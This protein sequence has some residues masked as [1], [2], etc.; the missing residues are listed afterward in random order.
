[1]FGR[2]CIAELKRLVRSKKYMFWTFAFPIMLGTLFYFAFSTI[3]NSQKSETIPVVIEV[4]DNAFKITLP[5]KNNSA[6]P[7]AAYANLKKREAEVIRLFDTQKTITRSIVQEQLGCSQTTAI[8]ILR[9]LVE[10]G[11]LV[12]LHGGMNTVY[13]KK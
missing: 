5:N 8:N 4:T 2:I 10:K 1:M 12:R 6:L 7:E 3:Y 13:Y 11:L 9:D